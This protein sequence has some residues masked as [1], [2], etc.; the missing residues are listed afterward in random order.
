M[1]SSTN[2]DM[3]LSLAA[4]KPA[5][6]LGPTFQD[7]TGFTVAPFA[8]DCTA[9]DLKLSAD[10]YTSA[11]TAFRVYKGRGNATRRHNF[12]SNKLSEELSF[13]TEGRNVLKTWVQHGWPTWG[14]GNVTNTVMRSM[15]Y[16]FYEY[17]KKYSMSEPVALSR[18]SM[19]LVY[20]A[21]AVHLFGPDAFDVPPDL[22]DEDKQAFVKALVQSRWESQGKVFVKTRANVL[23]AHEGLLKELNELPDDMPHKKV[24]ELIGKIKN[25]LTRS[26][27]FGDEAVVDR[28]EEWSEKLAEMRLTASKNAPLEADS[29]LPAPLRKALKE[30]ASESYVVVVLGELAEAAEALSEEALERDDDDYNEMVT[31]YEVGDWA[32]GVERFETWSLEQLWRYLGFRDEILGLNTLQD[33]NGLV[34]PWDERPWADLVARNKVTELF[35]FWHQVVGIAELITRALNGKPSLLMDDVG[36]GKT[37]QIVGLIAVYAHYF[38]THKRTGKFP[39]AFEHKQLKTQS[40]NL[41]DRPHLIIVPPSLHTQ[42]LRELH[43]FLKFGGFDVLPYT[44]AYSADR[45]KPVWDNMKAQRAGLPLCRR[46][47]LAT[48]AAVESDAAHYFW[49]PHAHPPVEPTVD[50]GRAKTGNTIFEWQRGF[51]VT[52]MDEAA[53]LRNFNNVY[54]ATWE[55][56][57]KSHTRIAM[58]ATPIQNGPMDLFNIGL[59]LNL[60]ECRDGTLGEKIKKDMAKAARKAT[61]EFK[62][63][64]QAPDFVQKLIAREVALPMKEAQMTTMHSYVDKF[65]KAFDGVVIH[66]TIHSLDWNGNPISG[67]PPLHESVLALQPSEEEKNALMVMAD[68]IVHD[69]NATKGKYLNK[70]DN[71]FYGKFRRTHTHYHLM[72]DPFWVPRSL[73]E[74]EERPSTKLKNMVEIIKWH[75]AEDGRAPLRLKVVHNGDPGADLNELEIDPDYVTL[76]R[77]PGAAP[78]KIVIFVAFP[79]NNGLITGVLDLINAKYVEVNGNKAAQARQTDID[80]FK[81]ADRDGPRVCLLSGVGMAGLNLAEASIVIVLDSLWSHQDLTQL[82]GRVWRHPQEKQVIVYHPLLKDSTEMSLTVLSCSKQ[83]LL[84]RFSDKKSALEANQGYFLPKSMNGD[85]SVAEQPDPVDGGPEAQPE[86]PEEEPEEETSAPKRK[87]RKPR[88]KKAKAG[89][90]A[91]PPEQPGEESPAPATTS[92]VKKPK[93]KKGQEAPATAANASGASS[94]APAKTPKAKTAPAVPAAESSGEER[95][96]APAEPSKGKGKGKGKAAGAPT[97]SE[98]EQDGGSGQSGKESGAPIENSYTPAYANIPSSRDVDGMNGHQRGSATKKLKKRMMQSQ[99]ADERRE[100]RIALHYLASKR[101]TTTAENKR[102]KVISPATIDD[103]DEETAPPAHTYSG[104]GALARRLKD[105]AA[106][107]SSA[108]SSVPPD[109]LSTRMDEALGMNENSSLTPNPSDQEQA[110]DAMDVDPK[111]QGPPQRSPKSPHPEEP[112]TKR[113][114]TYGASSPPPQPGAFADV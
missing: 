59:A 54:I 95:S 62:A 22:L 18:L 4:D 17:H 50:S 35:P 76:V 58:T 47:I 89:R 100:L 19:D 16:D 106:A 102:K 91:A 31:P 15:G 63:A 79:S 111:E 77:P 28:M 66:R 23:Q 105:Q 53:K 70:A 34:D 51:A 10:D 64:R 87:P 109:E 29:K 108:T 48:T 113:P 12:L 67:L 46:I 104:V 99:D 39:G 73:A 6:F 36:V 98:M 2:A 24:V 71:A 82:L 43:R 96:A 3:I 27:R 21:L 20:R 9:D 25:L 37:L 103:S 52:V 72:S 74:W 38:E 107:A 78:D 84:M 44:H 55:L 60:D 30:L 11:D 56:F 26:R 42:W 97:P 81:Q 57:K 45:R 13:Y 7:L 69:E 93:G 110:G 33:P 101:A 114:R 5:A 88:A 68:E 86:E 90:S 65:R 8:D 49:R 41:P 32:S 83:S 112:Q 61:Q 92:K 80:A 1:P 75:L 14:F 85:G 40:G 94:S